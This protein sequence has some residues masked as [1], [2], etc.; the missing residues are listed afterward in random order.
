MAK[1][2]TKKKGSSSKKKHKEPRTKFRVGVVMES[3]RGGHY[4]KFQLPTNKDGESIYDENPFPLT[5]NEGD[6]INLTTPLDDLKYRVKQGWLEKSEAKKISKKIPDYL[7]YLATFDTEQEHEESEDNDD[8]EESD[9]SDFEDDDDDE[10]EDD[11][12]D[13]P[14]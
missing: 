3:K 8:F 11:D 14:F 7:E 5:I 1:K 10:F 4:L 2:K 13:V 9:D 12:D 6:Y